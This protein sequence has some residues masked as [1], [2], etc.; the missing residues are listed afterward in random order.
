MTVDE[1]FE[2]Y[3]KLIPEERQKFLNKITKWLIQKV[4]DRN[5][6]EEEKKLNN[7]GNSK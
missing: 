7:D 3:I 1:I 6:L 4:D 2:E 5:K